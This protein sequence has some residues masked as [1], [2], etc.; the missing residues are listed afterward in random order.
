M[1]TDNKLDRLFEY[2]SH[3][4]DTVALS[5]AYVRSHFCEDATP[6]EAYSF[7]HTCQ[8][9]RL[10]P[11]LGEAHL[12]KY[13]KNAA[14]QVVLSYMAWLKRAADDPKYKGREAG[15][16]LEKDGELHY[17]QGSIV[18][19]KENLVGGWAEV[20]V[21]G[22][23]PVRIE[24][25]MTEYN[26]NTRPW[27]RMP[28][29]MIQKVALS[30]AH[31]MAFPS[32]FQGLNVGDDHEHSPMIIDVEGGVVRDN[33]DNNFSYK[34]SPPLNESNLESNSIPERLKARI[35]EEGLTLEEFV[36]ILG[37]KSYQEWRD[38][39]K[40]ALDAWN[41]YATQKT[42]ESEKSDKND[43]NDESVENDEP[44]ENIDIEV[45]TEEESVNDSDESTGPV[46]GEAMPLPW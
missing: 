14:A 38:S 12:V 45:S 32:L 5:V 21:E 43:V 2:Q 7:I 40:S 34:T 24:V 26:Q 22:R 35:I 23:M 15:I 18:L 17:R 41:L 39:G 13:S 16:V 20:H 33:N 44:I 28:A 46:E 30:Q 11:I 27:Q 36:A 42:G 6:A 4:G 19:S 31:R 8:S 29:T 10:N 25:S 37:V 9:H 3:G 1:T